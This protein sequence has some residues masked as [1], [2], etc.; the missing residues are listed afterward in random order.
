MHS[1]LRAAAL[2]NHALLMRRIRWIPVQYTMYKY[3][4]MLFACLRMTGVQTQQAQVA[5]TVQYHDPLS[6]TR[7]SC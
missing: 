3:S 6:R 4:E 7:L 1:V 5:R 2:E